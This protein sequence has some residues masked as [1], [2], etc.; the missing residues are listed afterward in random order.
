MGFLPLPRRSHL[1]S[2][3]LKVF[4]PKHKRRY[5]NERTVIVPNYPDTDVGRAQAFKTEPQDF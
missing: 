2:K 4:N 5:G 3:A 1:K